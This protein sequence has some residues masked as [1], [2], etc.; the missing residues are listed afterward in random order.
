MS[1]IAFTYCILALTFSGLAGATTI[2]STFDADLDGWTSNPQG[3]LGF[4]SAGGDPDGYL[5]EIDASS[6]GNMHVIAPGKFLGDLSW[7]DN[8][9]VDLRTYDTPITVRPAF[10]TLT[11]L[12]SAA[13]LSMSLDLGA[14]STVWTNYATPLNSAVFGVDAATYF[15]VMGNVTGVTLILEAD[16]DSDT[17]KVAMDNFTVSGSLSPATVPEPEYCGLLGVALIVGALV[18]RKRAAGAA[19]SRSS[20]PQLDLL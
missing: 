5:E 12:N 16:K 7:A 2:I 11:F 20:L 13:A 14:P 8:F 1:T 9:S 3:T 17:E 4:V 6:G 10:G 19:R 18:R 15:A